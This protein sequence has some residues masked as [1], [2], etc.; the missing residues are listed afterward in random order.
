[1]AATSQ[2]SICP[3]KKSVLRPEGLITCIAPGVARGNAKTFS[4]PCKGDTLTRSMCRTY[5][6]PV[7]DLPTPR[8][9]I[10][11]GG[12]SPFALSCEHRLFE[13]NGVAA[14]LVDNVLTCLDAENMAM[15]LVLP[16]YRVIIAVNIKNFSFTIHHK[17]GCNE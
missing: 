11:R 14:G 17:W 8:A 3:G 12:A 5:S 2:P 15:L 10:P 4:E 16:G 9:C 1:M 7:T 6:A 13:R